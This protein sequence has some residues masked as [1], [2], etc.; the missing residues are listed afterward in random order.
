MNQE[1]FEKIKNG[2]GFI[3][4]L[5]QSG[6]STPKALKDYGIEENQYSN[7]DE[8]YTL[9]HEMRTRIITSPAFSSE[10]ILGAILFEQTMDRE[11]EGK[12]TSDYLADKGIVPFLKVDKGLA[13]EENGVQL[14][15]VIPGL[16]ELLK[17]AKERNVFGTKMRS[18]IL[19]ANKD[20]IAKVV[21]QQF[22]I[23]KQIIEAGLAP[24]IE[25]EVNINAKDKE[26]IEDILK[27]EIA[28][29]LDKL[30][31][32]QYVMLKLTIPTK[33]NQYKSLIEHPNVVRVVALSGGY[34]REKANELLKENDN[35]I[36]SFSRALVTDLFAGQSAE[37]FDS[38]LQDAVD[39]IY[40]AS[41]NK[42]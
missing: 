22:E 36:A 33:P 5:D 38:G 31:E 37:E 12:Y 34:S 30:N 42:N 32:D 14:M 9:V 26:A 16:D 17:R 29:E 35:L 11:V 13:D 28:K 23:G 27:D 20:A 4:A 25:P 24:I 39:S 2:K 41:V 18:N 1:Q 3:A 21:E 40:D 10:K 6:G 8:M 15:K 7:E 19:E